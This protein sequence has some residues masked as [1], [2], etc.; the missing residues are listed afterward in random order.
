MPIKVVAEA[1]YGLILGIAD[2]YIE[3]I[4]PPGQEIKDEFRCIIF[5]LP[6]YD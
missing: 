4:V 6:E 3:E 1:S 2:I 5:N